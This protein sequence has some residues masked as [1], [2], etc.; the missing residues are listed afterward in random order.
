MQR[1]AT[2]GGVTIGI[3]T[4]ARR[5]AMGEWL[6]SEISF[7][8]V[9]LQMWMLIV[10]HFSLFDCSTFG[11]SGSTRALVA[12]FVV[13]RGPSTQKPSDCKPRGRGKFRFYS[14]NVLSFDDQQQGFCNQQFFD[15]YVMGD[16]YFA[17]NVG[18][19]ITNF[20]VACE[21]FEAIRLYQITD[22]LMNF[23]H[24]T[25][26]IGFLAFAMAGKET[27]CSGMDD[28]GDVITLLK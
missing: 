15:G 22:F 12:S 7:A 13:R 19:V 3:V 21:G 5:S 8:G 24:H 10:L 17:V 16:E 11:C 18:T 20:I 1:P 4:L 9:H 14:R 23:P 6:I 27:N 26:Q 25:L 2:G 28:S